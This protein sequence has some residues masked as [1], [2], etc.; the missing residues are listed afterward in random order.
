MCN[1]SLIFF[2]NFFWCNTKFYGQSHQTDPMQSITIRSVQLFCHKDQCLRLCYNRFTRRGVC[3]IDNSNIC[4]SQAC[5]SRI[6][7]GQHSQHLHMWFD[8][9][10]CKLT[11]IRFFSCLRIICTE[12]NASH[13]LPEFVIYHLIIMFI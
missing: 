2:W 1:G 13:I 12:Q 8:I 4:C 10:L 5:C 11:E 6:L 7:C 9:S 3:I